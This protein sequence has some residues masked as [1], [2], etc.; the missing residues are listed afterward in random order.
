MGVR[1]KRL[2]SA[3]RIKSEKENHWKVVIL[4]MFCCLHI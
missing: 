4:S 1:S 3:D 2:K